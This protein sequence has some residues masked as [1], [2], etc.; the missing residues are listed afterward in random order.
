ERSPGASGPPGAPPTPRRR[1]GSDC[2]CL[3]GALGAGRALFGGRLHVARREH[4][5]R[6]DAAPVGAQHAALAALE[7]RGLARARQ[8]P[9]LLHEEAGDGV[10]ALLLGQVR[11]EVLVEFLDARGAAHRE[12]PLGVAADVLIVLDVELIVD[13]AHDLLDHVLDGAQARD[14]PV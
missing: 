10:H 6:I 7:A 12:L 14:A 5:Q 11:A 3:S 13:V 4:T 1:T 9:E 8:P 2:P